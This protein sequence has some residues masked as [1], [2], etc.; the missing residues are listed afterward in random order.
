MKR[1]ISP[2]PVIAASAVLLASVG[3]LASILWQRPP[4]GLLYALDDAYIHLSLA[5]NLSSHGAWSLS[6]DG[7]N[8]VASS[9]LW[10]WILALWDRLGGPLVW[11]PFILG[12]CLSVCLLVFCDRFVRRAAPSLGAFTRFAFLLL[13]AAATPLPALIFSGLDH[14]LQVA[15]VVLFAAEFSTSLETRDADGRWRVPVH[16]LALAV[17]MTAV[18]YEGFSLILPAVLILAWRRRF[19]DALTVAIGALVP[20]AVYAVAA[21]RHGGGWIPNPLLLKAYHPSLGSGI[22]V[23]KFLGGRAIKNALVAPHILALVLAALLSLARTRKERPGSDVCLGLL[24]LGSALLHLQFGSVG[25]FFRYEAYL[26][27]L[28]LLSVVAFGRGFVRGAPG[29]GWRPRLGRTAIVL[30]L[31]MTLAVRSVQA[32]VAIPAAVAD[33]YRKHWFAA[34]LIR[35][36]FNG[37]VVV[38]NDIGLASFQTRARILDLYGLGSEEP[39]RYRHSSRGYGPEQVAEWVG[40]AGGEI[41]ILEAGWP[42]V[43]RLVPPEWTLV[44]EW[45]FPRDVVFHDDRIEF[46]AISRGLAPSLA[47]SLARIDRDLPP[48]IERRMFWPGDRSESTKAGSAERKPS[49]EAR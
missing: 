2:G 23:V 11:A 12:I 28:G 9:L 13:V 27:P 8:P 32:I 43:A 44:A 39:N 29:E 10:P 45:K 3:T 5:R 46:Y 35:R 25:W 4:G 17:L 49:G 38:L 37:S 24:F 26:V 41:A 36:S 20:P 22:E 30:L 15:V 7:W 18:R 14:V 33:R 48:E 6:G 1:P 31:A 16:L 47:D 42:F 19:A 34:E 40:R 21:S